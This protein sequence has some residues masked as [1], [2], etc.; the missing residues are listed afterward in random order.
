ME[1]IIQE[2]TDLFW[3]YKNTNDQNAYIAVEECIQIVL[4]NKT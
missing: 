1:K 4:K 2:L 3:E